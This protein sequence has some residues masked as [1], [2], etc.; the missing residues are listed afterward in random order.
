MVFAKLAEHYSK[1][2]AHRLGGTF[3]E[4][5]DFLR[6]VASSPL[7]WLPPS[8]RLILR[9]DPEP[10]IGLV[11]GVSQKARSPTELAVYEMRE[12][13]GRSRFVTHKDVADLPSA[14]A[15]KLQP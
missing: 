1:W 11:G 15:D 10:A 7:E 4:P 8:S 13:L 12:T 9:A 3:T 6:A 2:S 14:L 5:I